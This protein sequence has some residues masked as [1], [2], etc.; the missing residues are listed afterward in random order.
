MK[1]KCSLRTALAELLVKCYLNP[2]AGIPLGVLGH[3]PQA[4]ASLG[5]APGAVWS[6]SLSNTAQQQAS[7]WTETAQIY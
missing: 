7:G 4:L 5:P 6:L 3:L 1:G 2:G